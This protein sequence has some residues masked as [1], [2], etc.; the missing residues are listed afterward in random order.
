[1]GVCFGVVLL[2][3]FLRHLLFGGFGTPFM[4]LA[5]VGLKYLI[6]ILKTMFYC[7]RCVRK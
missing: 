7:M 5:S 6:D 3:F 4:A 1:M 2:V